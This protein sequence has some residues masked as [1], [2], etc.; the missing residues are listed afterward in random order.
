MAEFS[1]LPL[2]TDAWLSDTGHLSRAERGLYMDLL[3]L[4]WRSPECRIPNDE[5]WIARKLRVGSDETETLREVIAEFMTSSGNW[6]WQ[7]RLRREFEYVRKKSKKQSVS[8]KARWQKEKGRCG[9]NTTDMPDNELWHASG[10]APTP[11]PTPLSKQVSSVHSA[12]RETED[13]PPFLPPEDATPRCTNQ[14]DAGADPSRAGWLKAEIVKS[15]QE[16]G[17]EEKTARLLPRTERVDRWIAQGYHAQICLAVVQECL[18][19]KHDISSLSYF[20]KPIAEA[21]EKPREAAPRPAVK[22]P[23]PSPEAIEKMWLWKL[24][25]RAKY[26]SFPSITDREIDIPP[27]VLAKWRAMRAKLKQPQTLDTSHG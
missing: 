10:N 15:Y 25:W 22:P 18:A 8:A 14:R 24:D 9:G 11:T 26:G 23:D 12:A 21:H 1:A 2:F 27:G 7:K 17:Y 6:L 3:I 5:Q 16:V 13:V 19:K 20:D 4:C